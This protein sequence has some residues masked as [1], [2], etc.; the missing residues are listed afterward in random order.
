LCGAIGDGKKK[1]MK[2]ERRK[3]EIDLANFWTPEEKSSGGV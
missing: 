3:A 1:V 2:N